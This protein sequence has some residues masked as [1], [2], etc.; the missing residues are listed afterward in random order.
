M[1]R[2]NQQTLKWLQTCDSI[3]SMPSGPQAPYRFGRLDRA[4]RHYVPTNVSGDLAVSQSGELMHA[5]T[6]DGV[7][8]NASFKRAVEVWQDLIIGVGMQTLA[9]PFESWIDLASLTADELDSRLD[10]ALESDELYSAWFGEAKQFD[11]E[12][13]L[14]GTDF[15]R[16]AIAELVTVGEVF[17]VEHI[18]PSLDGESVPLCYQLIEADQLCRTHNRQ[19]TATQ[20]KIVDGIEL[21]AWNREVAYYLYDDNQNDVA[22]AS[23]NVTRIEAD[24]C[25]HLYR[26]QRPTQHLGASELASCAQ[27]MVDRDKLLGTEL[28]TAAKVAAVAL[29][30]KNRKGS[31]GSLGIAGSSDNVDQ[32]GNEEVRLGSSPM[33]V[34]I[35]VDEDVQVV[36]STRPNPDIGVFLKTVDLDTAAGAGISPYSLRGNYEATSFSSA[37]AA[38]IDEDQHFAPLQRW[39]AAMV[40]L[41]MRRRFNELAALMGLL[42]NATPQ[43][44][45]ANRSRYQRFEALGP[46]RD[47]LDPAAE[48]E[49]AISRLRGSLSTLKIECGRRG[50]HWVRVLRQKAIENR[51][52]DVLGVVLDF[53]KGQGGQVTASTTQATQGAPANG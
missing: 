6:R 49:A 37:R 5:R 50:L 1:S 13:R 27:P 40:A 23:Q 53:S 16:M 20:N 18:R 28:Q 8:N 30:H 19:R 43:E 12:S 2:A 33:S 3:A 38:K 11:A 17:I 31:A 39:F 42:V 25:W 14:T 41:P 15:Q 35:G 32:Y 22:S 7:R 47:L 52:A 36:E 24:R 51:V 9:D 26:P 21:D 10:Y 45:L 4:T 29:V 44:F 46:G 34:H 48:T